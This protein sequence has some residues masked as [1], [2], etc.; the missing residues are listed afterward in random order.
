MINIAKRAKY[1][2]VVNVDW[3][4]LSHRLALAL[5]MK[6]LGYEVYILTKDTGRKD[7]IIKKGL[8]FIDVDF[9]RSGKNPLKELNLINTLGKLYKRYN[10]SI[11]HHV[12]IKPVVYGSIAAKK[13]RGAKVV[14]AVSGLGFNFIDGRNGLLQKMLRRLM[15]YAFSGKVNFIFQNPDDLDMYRQMGFLRKDNYRLIKGAGV[16]AAE[17]P[18]TPPQPNKEKLLVV[19]TARMLYDKGIN[20]LIEAAHMLRE[21]LYGKVCFLLV[22]DLDKD[23]PAGIEKDILVSRLV[24]GYI[25]W[26]GHK[27]DVREVL[28]PSDIVCLP[29]YREGLPKSLIEAMAVGRPIITTDAPGC[30]ECVD[31]Q[32]N[33]ILVPVKS[34]KELA[35]AIE[36]LAG[37][38]NMRIYMG[39]ASRDKMVRELSLEKVLKDTIAFYDAI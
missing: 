19:T 34:V 24:P 8:N 37:D 39:K 33:G 26:L 18:Y 30:R 32:V 36:T 12:T 1:F 15:K 20:E 25:E 23:N 13:L 31:H 7:E 10:P 38:D 29:S 35:A 22:G 21:K 6:R 5:E 9:E 11:I 14:N 17:F 4:F 27:K 16:D 2:L 28:I 3:F